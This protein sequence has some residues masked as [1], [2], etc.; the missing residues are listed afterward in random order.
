MY[1]GGGPWIS[2]FACACCNFEIE[3]D[4]ARRDIR[5]HGQVGTCSEHGPTSV[6]VNCRISRHYGVCAGR[7]SETH[8]FVLPRLRVDTGETDWSSDDVPGT[9][10]DFDSDEILECLSTLQQI[11]H[12]ENSR[13]CEHRDDQSHART[14]WW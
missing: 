12:G 5:R 7:V 14:M 10:M 6:P 1:R 13:A 4:V 9:I 8:I 11:A 2:S 3:V